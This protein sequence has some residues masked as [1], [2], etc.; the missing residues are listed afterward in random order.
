MVDKKEDEENIMEKNPFISYEEED[1]TDVIDNNQ[2]T[3][4]GNEFIDFSYLPNKVKNLLGILYDKFPDIES[5][6]N[7]QRKK[8][9]EI[10]NFF[11]S[12]NLIEK[13]KEIDG[14]IKD[15]DDIVNKVNEI[16]DRT[17]NIKNT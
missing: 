16:K 9:K 13:D 6:L 11:N 7:E 5:E 17:Q 14:I 2:K 10:K 1:S 8:Y 4:L 12:V 15:I 3:T